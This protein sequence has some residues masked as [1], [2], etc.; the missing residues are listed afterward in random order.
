[1]KN[2]KQI[3]FFSRKK[4][5][6]WFFFLPLLIVL[7]LSIG[8]MIAT[9]WYSIDYKIAA[10]LAKG[11]TTEFGKYWSRF[12]ELLGMTELFIVIIIYAAIILE[13]W[14]LTKIA[15]KNQKFTKNYWVV[16]TFYIVIFIIW[17]GANFANIILA[18]NAN[19]GFGKGIDHVL[20]DDLKYKLT[21]M[22]VAFILQTIL[23]SLGLYY[24]KYQ[25]VKKQRLL[26]EQFWLKAVK[27]LSFAAITYVVIVVLKGTTAKLYYYN[28]I[29]G[30]LINEHPDL[31]PAY[32]ESGFKY[33]YNN[34]SGWIANIPP[35]LQYPWWKPNLSLIQADAN[36]PRFTMPWAYAFPSGHINA[37][38]CTGSGILLFLKNKDNGKVNWKIK[39][40][41]G[42]WLA[43]VLSMNFALVVERFHWISDTAFTFVFSTLMIL[44]IH[45]SVNQIFAKRIK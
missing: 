16:D 11:L 23:L 24:V 31:L 2:N 12:Y 43:H 18:T 5:S 14:F 27:G 25:L 41:F 10:E 20:L 36:M 34:G 15:K 8:V 19:T 28:A 4:S 39:V 32:Q 6:W 40:V 44:V 1:M 37:T 22:V 29:F 26:T 30:D 3:N 21:G 38:Y 9:G 45:F 13:T 33:G 7:L 42:L 35:E 17:V